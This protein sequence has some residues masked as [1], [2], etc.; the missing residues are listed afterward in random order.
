MRMGSPEELAKQQKEPTDDG[1]EPLLPSSRLERAHD[2]AGC[3]EIYA[4]EPP[5]TPNGE[6]VKRRAPGASG[7][8]LAAPRADGVASRLPRGDEGF[9]KRLVTR[10][11]PPT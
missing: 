3:V 6:R 11:S 5:V 1:G 8:P 4:P 9:E 10:K 2:H 7:F